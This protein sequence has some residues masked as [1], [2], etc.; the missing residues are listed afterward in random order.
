M[1]PNAWLTRKMVVPKASHVNPIIA[2]VMH[3]ISMPESF[4]SM[5][6][7]WSIANQNF[8]SLGLWGWTKHMFLRKNFIKLRSSIEVTNLQ[9]LEQKM[10]RVTSFLCLLPTHNCA[11]LQKKI[12]SKTIDVHV[13]FPVFDNMWRTTLF[14]WKSK[15]VQ[16]YVLCKIHNTSRIHHSH[17]S[18]L[19]IGCVAHCILSLKS[20]M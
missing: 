6:G 4:I 20:E 9:K 7:R 1:V 5:I 14:S 17:T 3:S 15:L 2:F 8:F 18:M 16:P 11:N 13:L 10:D 12:K 19:F